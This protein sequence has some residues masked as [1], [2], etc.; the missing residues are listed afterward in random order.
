MNR[1]KPTVKPPGLY[2]NEA[3]LTCGAAI[4]SC[5][6]CG[7]FFHTADYNEASQTPPCGCD[8]YDS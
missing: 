2:F 7:E 3:C 6:A 4:Q 1:H 5:D 8:E